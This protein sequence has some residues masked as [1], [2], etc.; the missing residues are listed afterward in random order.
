MLQIMADE[1]DEMVWQ[2]IDAH[3]DWWVERVQAR[4]KENVEAG[5]VLRPPAF[6][7]PDGSALSVYGRPF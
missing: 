2:I 6:T 1:R 4:W 5:M 3:D 7:F